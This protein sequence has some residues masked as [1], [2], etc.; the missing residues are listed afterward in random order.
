MTTRGKNYL[1]KIKAAGS[2]YDLQG[3]ELAFKQ[4]MK[5]IWE[6]LERLCNAAEE[7]RVS[8]RTGT[9]TSSLKEVLFR[10]A[11]AEMDAYHNM[12]ADSSCASEERKLQHQRFRGVYQIIK[13]AELEDEYDAWR[14][15][16]GK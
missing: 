9:E 1:S 14:Q 13:E 7:K 15:A 5:L 12:R 6:E 11:K 16:N 2:L 3:I 10:R 8:L 4:D